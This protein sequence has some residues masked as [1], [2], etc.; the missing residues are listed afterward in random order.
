MDGSGYQGGIGAAVI[1][2]RR[3]KPE[4]VLRFHLGSQE[5]Y[6]VFNGEQ[7]GMLLG[8]ELLCREHNAHSVYMG[9]NNQ[10]AIRATMTFFIVF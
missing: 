9:V 8:V 6:M 1:L 2:W 5:H 3:G 4:K 7:I 10:A